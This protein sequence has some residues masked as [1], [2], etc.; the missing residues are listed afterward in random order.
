MLNGGKAT[1][2]VAGGVVKIDQARVTTAD[3]AASNGI[4]HVIDAALLPPAALA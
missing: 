2:T 4:I 3:V 1:F